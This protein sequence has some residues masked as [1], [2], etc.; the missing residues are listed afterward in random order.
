MG[1]KTAACCRAKA[2]RQGLRENCCDQPNLIAG[3]PINLLK[4]LHHFARSEFRFAA[5]H[6]SL[7]ADQVQLDPMAETLSPPRLLPSGDSRHH[8][9]IQPHHRRRRQPARAARSTA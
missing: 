7:M 5:K 2:L 6:A 8:G 1:G 3:M 4:L 9:G